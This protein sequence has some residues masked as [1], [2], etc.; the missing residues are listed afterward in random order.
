[1]MWL[2]KK[3]KK[4]IISSDNSKNQKIIKSDCNINFSNNKIEKL[5]DNEERKNIQI[6]NKTGD[7]KREKMTFFNYL[8]YKIFCGKKYLNIKVYE[9]FREKIISEEQL[10]KNYFYINKLKMVKIETNPYLS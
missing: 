9:D 4:K 7:K 8:V 10:F 2:R 5:K 1:M 6:N 3:K